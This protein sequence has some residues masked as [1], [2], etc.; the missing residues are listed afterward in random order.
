MNASEICRAKTILSDDDISIIESMEANLQVVAD[1]TASDIFVDCLAKNGNESVVVSQAKPRY[2]CVSMYE[3]SVVGMPVY[4]ENEPAVFYAFE[5]GMPVRDLKA[6]TQENVTVKQVVVPIKT[7]ESHI[8]GVLISERD[9][10]VN[11]MHEKK[12]NELARR[13]EELNG[14]R[15]QPDR[16][17]GDMA[18]RE[19]HHR[20]K[21]GLQLL[22]SVMNLQAR[23]SKNPDVKRLFESNTA[24]VLS[25]A[26]THDI[27]TKNG[28]TG[29][30]SLLEVLKRII[31]NLTRLTE[32]SRSIEIDI[33]GTDA[34]VN[35]DIASS[36]AL[37][38][39]EL[40]SNSIMHGYEDGDKGRI[41]VNI[42]KGGLDTS[43]WIEDDGRGFDRQ[44]QKDGQLGLF[45][46]RETVRDKLGG[47]FFIS[48]SEKGTRA[49]FSF[50]NTY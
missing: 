7:D 30:L 23:Q 15:F 33:E 36:V 14:M 2:G 1:L 43:I 45:L 25:I 37:V 26:S 19:M 50:K 34:T 21:N 6:V 32:S 18:A 5:S 28:V 22:A 31:D 41:R 11:I 29:N 47:D 38:V 46:V 3:G 24:R 4:R 27:I 40:V 13:Q 49:S 16:D 48:S 42:H 20:V 44:F 17:A 39:N 12:F 8:I 10:S 9:I 35:A